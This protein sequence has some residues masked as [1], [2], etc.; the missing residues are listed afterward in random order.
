MS[1]V[2]PKLEIYYPESDGRPLGETDL[3]IHWMIRVRDILKRH[4]RGQ[5]VYV[6]SNLFLYYTKGL[7]QHVVA[8]DIFVVKDCDPGFRRVYKLWEEQQPPNVVFEI[9]SRETRREDE[10]FKPEKYGRIGVKEYFIYD[11]SNDYLEPALQG[12]RLTEHD[13]ERIEP[14]AQGRLHC[15]ELNFWLRT[16]MGEMV[17]YDAQSGQRL[18]TSE[19]A[20]AEAKQA[21]VAAQDAERAAR[22]AELAAKEIELAA[23]EA[24]LAAKES[25]LAA[26]ATAVAERAAREAAEAELQ[27]LREELRRGK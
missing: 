23:R 15:R 12:F 13:C 25:E 6:A 22:S 26:K 5:R 21:V 24:E 7:P 2:E 11:P 27:K 20:E 3:H 4:Y 14:D 18:L 16:E 10:S 1:I 9:T 19:E 17:I 8:P